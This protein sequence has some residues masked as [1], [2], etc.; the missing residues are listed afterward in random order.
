MHC[1]SGRLRQHS[2]S[3]PG[4]ALSRST[5]GS[6]IASRAAG[7]DS[8]RVTFFGLRLVATVALDLILL[9]DFFGSVTALGLQPPLLFSNDSRTIIAT[10]SAYTFK[11]LMVVTFNRLAGSLTRRHRD[12]AAPVGFRHCQ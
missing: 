7:V 8:W 11:I 10:E 4:Q 1:S 9:S 2:A 5:S 6:A 12:G 3:A